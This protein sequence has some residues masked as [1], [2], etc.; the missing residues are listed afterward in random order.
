MDRRKTRQIRVGSVNVGSNS[1]VSVQSMCTTKTS[2]VDSTLAQIR[3]LTMA[4]CEIVR[5]AVPGIKDADALEKIVEGSP[6][7]VVADIHFQ[8]LYVFRALEAGCAGVRVNPGNIKKFDDQV[9]EICHAAKSNGAS[10]RIGVNAGSL[11]KRLEALY[12]TDPARALRDSALREAKLFEDNGF[13]DFKISV[14]HHNVPIMIKAYEML[15]KKGDWPLHLGVTEAGPA[16]QGTIKSSAAFAVLLNQG[17]GD[18]L[19]VSLTAD[20]VEEVKVGITLLQSLGLR[21]KQLEIVSCPTCGRCE[22]E[23]IELTTRVEKALE[24]IKTPIT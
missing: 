7:P 13:Y 19:R 11:D 15:A 24:G 20:P 4:G 16:F 2:D 14:K 22:I 10:L 3:E 21:E 18:T 8:P 17:I 12:K 6:I 9:K 23:V 5:V 1:P